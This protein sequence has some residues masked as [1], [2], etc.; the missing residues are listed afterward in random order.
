[1]EQVILMIESKNNHQIALMEQMH[2]TVRSV[3]RRMEESNFVVDRQM[4][5]MGQ[6]LSILTSVYRRMEEIK[7]VGDR[8]VVSMVQMY[9][10]MQSVEGRMEETKYVDDRQVALLQSFDR[11]RNPT[12]VTTL[13]DIVM[14]RAVLKQHAEYGCI[15]NLEFQI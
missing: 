9:S 2:S 4:T 6:M 14:V 10:T 7:H 15:E 5:L 12:K 3:D 8:Q 1:M 11:W 13:S